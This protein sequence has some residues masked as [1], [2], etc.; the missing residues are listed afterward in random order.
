MYGN[1]IDHDE[2]ADSD[3]RGCEQRAHAIEGESHNEGLAQTRSGG[4]ACR[5]HAGASEMSRRGRWMQT[6]AMTAAPK[7]LNHL[8]YGR[9]N[10]ATSTEAT[11]GAG[12]SDHSREGADSTANDIVSPFSLH[13]YDH[14]D[15]R[16]NGD[17]HNG[18]GLIAK[19][20]KTR[21]RARSS[22]SRRTRQSRSGTSPGR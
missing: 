16:Q 22:R 10:R 15:K 5:V 7:T 14:E 8:A 9:G 21:A 4:P 6:V 3:E 2:Q 13:A 17:A 11:I 20:L 18:P 19:H 12:D 1:R